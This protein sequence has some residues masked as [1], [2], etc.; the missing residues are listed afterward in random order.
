MG[1]GGLSVFDR[2]PGMVRVAILVLASLVSMSLTGCGRLDKDAVSTE[3]KTL[4]SS[5][6]E[7]MLVAD[8]AA[9]SRA[10]ADFIEIRSAELSKQSRNSAD[11]LAETPTESGLQEAAMTGNQIGNRAS[12]LLD[13]LHSD[14]GDTNLATNVTRELR[15]LHDQAAAAEDSL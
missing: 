13:S 10:P 4:V 6:A 1:Q 2:P 9:R 14:P 8:Q 7:G 15:S 11:A 3:L 5:T 12:K